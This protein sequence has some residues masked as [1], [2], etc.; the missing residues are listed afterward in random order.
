VANGL[1]SGK[2]EISDGAPQPKVTIVLDGTSGD[3]TAGANGEIGA[4]VTKNQAGTEIARL[5][6][7]FAAV[8]GAPAGSPPQPLASGLLQLKTHN[9]QETITLNGATGAA[10]VATVQAVGVHVCDK[11]GKSTVRLSGMSGDIEAG[12]NGQIGAVVSK[13]QSGTVIGRLGHLFAA[14]PGSPPGAPPFPLASGQLVVANHDGQA[15]ITLNGAAG[16]VSAS[17]VSAHGVS[18]TRVSTHDLMVENTAGKDTIHLDGETGD[19]LLLNADCAE[20]FVVS[21]DGEVEPGTVMVIEGE[22]RLRCS[23]QPYDRRVAG[24]VSGAGDCR[25]GIVLGK[26]WMQHDAVAVAL[27]GKVYC[28]ADARDAPIAIGDLLTTS[29]TPGHAMKASDGARAAGAVIGKALRPLQDGTGLIPI[30]VAL[31]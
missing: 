11:D 21:D 9:G 12:G 14:L 4:M 26:K 22:D 23:E 25:P 16:S 6:H 27:I 10:S 19:I 2:V 31:Q 5:G 8:P 20:E 7:A 17:H 13:N 24:V 15:T 18:A 3:I 30:L 29:A 1:L 28:K